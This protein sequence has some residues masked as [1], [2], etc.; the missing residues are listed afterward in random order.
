MDSG[1][2]LMGHHNVLAGNEIRPSRVYQAI[3]NFSHQGFCS[4]NGGGGYMAAP[5]WGDCR[6]LVSDQL[7]RR[8]KPVVDQDIPC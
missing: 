3:P 8:L 4:S 6:D 7:K 5:T 2:I 1:C